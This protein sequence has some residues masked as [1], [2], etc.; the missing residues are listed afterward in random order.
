MLW[1]NF[2]N[3]IFL[4][5][6][7]P[8]FSSNNKYWI[9]IQPN[10]NRSKC[11]ELFWKVET[12][13]TNEQF[14]INFQ[15]VAWLQ[16]VQ[17][18]WNKGPPLFSYQNQRKKKITRKV[19]LTTKK[20]LCKKLIIAIIPSFTFVLSFAATFSVLFLFY[21]FLYANEAASEY[22]KQTIAWWLSLK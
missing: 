16:K 9:S 1:A 5:L 19:V 11:T 15:L 18:N 13:C 3:P 21:T 2:Q 14:E 12:Q 8:H 6:F 17:A 4:A 7:P 22:A 10:W 20:K